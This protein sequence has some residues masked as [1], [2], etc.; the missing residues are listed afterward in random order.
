[1]ELT[2][3][4]RKAGPRRFLTFLLFPAVFLGCR[5]DRK[6]ESGTRVTDALGQ[7][8][9]VPVSP[10]RIIS[11]APNITEILFAI[12]AGS[13]IAGVTD[14]CNFPE[15][16]RQKPKTGGLITPNPELILKMNPDLI[17][18]TADG[19]PKAIYDR[20]KNAGIP[21]FAI[22]PTGWGGILESVRLLGKVTGH[23]AAADSLAAD[24]DRQVSL[25]SLPQKKKTALI[26]LNESPLITAA[27]GSFLDDLL[28]LAGAGNPVPSGPERYPVINPEGLLKLDPDV[29]LWPSTAAFPA[30]FSDGPLKNLSAVRNGQVFRVDPDIFLR[31]GPRSVLAVVDLNR[32]LYP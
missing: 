5:P 30:S 8:V 20:A 12:G 10:E 27:R 26:L 29:I 6:P 15:A 19:N 7:Q 24:M 3:F 21:V 2:G 23:Q 25:L 1:M 31:P 18:V 17:L 28:A 11:L 13:Q 9:T 32:K 16:A 22:N 14:F 4:L